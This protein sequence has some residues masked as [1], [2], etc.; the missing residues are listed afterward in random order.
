MRQKLVNIYS[1]NDLM[2]PENR[3][4]KEKVIEKLHNINVEDLNWYDFIYGQYREDLETL[5]FYNIIFAFSGF[6]SQGSGTRIECSI[7]YGNAIEILDFPTQNNCEDIQITAMSSRY[8]H[9]MTL[10]IRGDETLGSRKVLSFIR[11]KSRELYK[12]LE[13]EHDNLTSEEAIMS[14][15]EANDYEFNEKGEME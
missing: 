15:I 7:P 2:L 13:K 9:E 4:I 3:A 10:E 11:E 8:L 1:H 12:D 5:G 6:H 14:T